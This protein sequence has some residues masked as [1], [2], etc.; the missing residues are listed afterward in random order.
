MVLFIAED[1]SLNSCESSTTIT[2]TSESAMFAED[3]SDKSQY[4]ANTVIKVE[5]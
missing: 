1:V 2:G 3:R 5:T 4:V